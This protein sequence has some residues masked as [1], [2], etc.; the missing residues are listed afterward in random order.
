MYGGK[1]IKVKNV[2]F[3][4]F[5]YSDSKV[6]F[7]G[8]EGEYLKFNYIT[9]SFQ[10]NNRSFCYVFEFLLEESIDVMREIIKNNYITYHNCNYKEVIIYKQYWNRS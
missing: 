8:Y 9:D 2:N 6:F 5:I 4:E 7:K 10:E 1:S 3:E